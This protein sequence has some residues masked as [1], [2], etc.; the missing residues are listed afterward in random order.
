MSTAL[1]LTDEPRL[2]AHLVELAA[3]ARGE[4]LP[5]SLSFERQSHL[6]IQEDAPTALPL[7]PVPIVGRE[8]ELQRL[9]SRLLGHGGRLLTLVG[10][11]G[12]GKTRL[13]L[14]MALRLQT[15]Y[16]DGSHFVALFA[17]EH[18]QL[19][20]SNIATELGIHPQPQ[21]SAPQQLIEH[22][23][24]KEM[25]LVLDNFEQLLH[26]SHGS[27]SKHS[28]PE[29][30]AATLLVAQILAEC[31]HIHLVVTSRERLHLRA[32]QRHRVQ[33]LDLAAAVALFVERM[34]ALE[35]LD[36]PAQ[37]QQKLV[38]EICHQLDCLPLAIE[39]AA[40]RV[41]VMS[42]ETLLAQLRAHR[43]DLLTDGA[44]D[45]PPHQRTLRRALHG[46][47]ALL[48]DDEQ[49]LFR[50]LGVF[51][52]G[53]DLEAV[54]GCGGA[55]S[56]LETLLNKN[57]LSAT[58]AAELRRFAM[59]HTVREFA[60]EMLIA[61]GEE[62]A[63]RQHHARYFGELAQVAAQQMHGSAKQRWLDQLDGEHD[64]L[65]AAL[66]WALG[67]D[68]QSA[69][70][71][72][73]ALE[74][75]WSTRGYEQEA[76]QGLGKALSACPQPT[77]LRARGLLALSSCERRL[78]L[79]ADAE[80]NLTEAEG[81]AHALGDAAL[82]LN[83]HHCA[84]W[85]YYDKHNYHQTIQRFEQG[86]ALAR[87][88]QDETFIVR[89]L[90]AIVHVQH[91]RPE[92]QAWV[93]AA[94]QECLQRLAG[95]DEPELRA[96]VLQ[97]YG[98]LEVAAG[99]YAAA[100]RH[101]QPMLEIYRMLDNKKKL[102]WGLELVGEVAW[103]QGNLPVAQQHYEAAH[104]LFAQLDNP[105]GL[106]IILHH[107]AQVARQQGRLADAEALYSQSLGY[108]HTLQNLHMTA[109][110][111]A[112]LGGVALLAG[113]AER[114]ALFTSAAQTQFDTLPPFLAPVDCE[115]FL[116]QVS[117]IQEQ[118][119]H[120]AVAVAGMQGQGLSM[121]E[122]LLLADEERCGLGGG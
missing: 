30:S 12:V 29:H 45:L 5:A 82:R 93:A 107:L 112:G 70:A 67:N 102:A 113:E 58:A 37:S 46:S 105:D 94:L 26:D 17:I 77:A 32:E 52:G 96:F 31:P 22:L 44:V 39:L 60:L 11:P 36:E 23:R 6:S 16:R 75:F 1:G 25:L 65:R 69:L 73:V 114:A 13:A 4:T 81:I 57:L 19:I 84:G 74:A 18:P 108:A 111:L 92:C 110:C 43:L 54:E 91:N 10:P 79:Y 78:G 27:S 47:Y 8:E 88:Q 87:T 76:R 3:R 21:K 2:A 40:A 15:L 101:Y 9:G 55:W 28:P 56:S 62:G 61:S 83:A 95:L 71:I 20:A 14:E 48:E 68:P 42:L 89:F 117:A 103:F 116:A 100:E 122:A 118:D 80:Q 66:R 98:A 63:A 49:R 59:L 35:W 34:Q 99:R 50:Q 7:P 109:R 90:V 33:P 86:L 72:A 120:P 38:E 106:M 104:A 97:Q 41:G 53:F 115:E 85:L 119:G 24:R 121:L 64:N 51:V